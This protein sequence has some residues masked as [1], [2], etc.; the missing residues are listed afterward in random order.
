MARIVFFGLGNMGRPMALNLQN[1]GHQLLG[2]DIVPS[3]R[4]AF[5]AAGGRLGDDEASSLADADFVFSMLPAGPHVRKL[6]EEMIIPH[7]SKNAILVDCSTI[8]VETSRLVGGLAA[9]AGIVMMDAPVSGGTVGAEAGTLTFMVGGDDG[10]FAKAKPLLD[11]M[12]K[13]IIH[14]GGHGNGQA[15]K[16]C[17]NMM[18][19]IQM[20]SVCEAF[21]LA[22]S[23]GLDAQKLYDISS[24][25]SGQCWSLTTYCPTP[26][27]VPTSPANRGYQPGFTAAMMR[28]DLGLA[29]Q[30]ATSSQVATPLG[31]QAAA[32][33]QMFCSAGGQD[34]DFSG[35]IRFLKSGQ[36]AGDKQ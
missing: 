16:I 8:D 11:I 36:A 29:E 22:E 25:A 1:A 27:P 18:L 9:D 3:M 17:N 32:L 12:G 14:A 4:D 28:K 7:V 23:L 10:G 13:N 30:A 19:G 33:Y 35:M 26:G 15:A 20:I 24:T 21:N 2:H 31:N 5:V 34:V 6:Y